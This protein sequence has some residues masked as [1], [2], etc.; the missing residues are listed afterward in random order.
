MSCISIGMM[1]KN[2]YWLTIRSSMD[3]GSTMTIAL[4]F[5]AASYLANEFCVISIS[6]STVKY[7]V[8]FSF[9]IFWYASGS[10]ACCSVISMRH[11]A[12][13]CASISGRF[14]SQVA[15]CSPISGECDQSRRRVGKP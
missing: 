5:M 7:V 3:G 15:K 2:E 10:R 11:T 12:Q 1:E 6:I 9:T 14:G 13:S 4:S 8:F